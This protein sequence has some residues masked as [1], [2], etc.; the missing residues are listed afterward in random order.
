MGR[1]AAVRIDLVGSTA[2]FCCFGPPHPFPINYLLCENRRTQGRSGEV[3]LAARTARPD[4]FGVVIAAIFIGVRL[5]P[6][7]MWGLAL[8]RERPLRG[9]AQMRKTVRVCIASLG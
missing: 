5:S 9:G 1:L 2:D 6:A 3:R 4:G 7:G 8:H